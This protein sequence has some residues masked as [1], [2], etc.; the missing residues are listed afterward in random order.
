MLWPLK[1]FVNLPILKD[2][3]ENNLAS[4]KIKKT[5]EKMTVLVVDDGEYDREF[6]V[7][8]LKSIGFVSIQTAENGRIATLK[9]ANALAI[10]RTFNLVFADWKMPGQDGY[11]LMKWIKNNPKLK[12]T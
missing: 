2:M 12:G 10:N 4:E 6:A 11:S 8:T 5:L 3:T 7:T 1:I 9:I